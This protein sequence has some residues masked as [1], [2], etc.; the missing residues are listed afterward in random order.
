MANGLPLVPGFIEKRISQ[1][2][3]RRQPPAG[4]HARIERRRLYIL[5]TSHGVT[6]FLAFILVLL[7][8]INYENSLAYMLAFLLGSLGLLA[9]IY[10]HQNI[11]RLE[12]RISRAEPV[13]AGQ[14]LLFPVTVSQDSGTPRAAIS[15][16]FESQPEIQLSLL[17]VTEASCK[18]PFKTS[19]RGYVQPGRI[20]VSTEFPLGLFHA[21]SWLKLDSQGL[22]YPAP[23]PR[24]YALS[25]EQKQSRGTLPN[26]KRGVEDFA[27]IRLYQ[28]GDQPSHLAWKAIARTGEML[29]RLYS[30]ESTQEVAIDWAQLNPSL[31]TEKRLSILCRQV[32]EADEQGLCYSF[33]IPGT[34]IGAA[35]GLQHKHRCLKA[36]ALFGQNQ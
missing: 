27:G 16:H 32:L 5:P 24:L 29:T 19:R 35:S 1:W 13:F 20:K 7:G 6:F 3:D 23:A 34:V 14:N 8:A 22:I 12:V 15:I 33:S 28:P 36:L 31:D 4:A 11:N 2:A 26:E 10:T 30:D 17:D 18:L 21:W 9:M 25:H